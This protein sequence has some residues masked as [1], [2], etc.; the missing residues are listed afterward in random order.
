MDLAVKLHGKLHPDVANNLNTLG[1][2]HQGKG[3]LPEAEAEMREA[4]RL[5][6]RSSANAT[7]R[8]PL[9]WETSRASTSRRGS[10]MKPNVSHKALVIRRELFGDIDR[11]VASSMNGLAMVL[12]EQGKMAECESLLRQS[13][14]IREKLL[15]DVHPEVA[16]SLNNL[17]FAIREQ[18]KLA[19]AETVFRRSLEMRKAIYGEEHPSVALAMNSLASVLRAQQNSTNPVRC[20]SARSR[21]IENS[22]ATK[23]RRW[24]SR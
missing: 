12:D 19:E 9:A 14:A 10:S 3:K 4:S 23:R 1:S 7:S 17:A 5:L 20:T 11:S 22:P 13:L 15:G 16:T 2:M 8:R 6:R 21:S 24:P 18:G